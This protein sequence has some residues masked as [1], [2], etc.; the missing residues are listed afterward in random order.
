M[1][2]RHQQG[3][4]TRSARPHPRRSRRRHNAQWLAA[5]VAVLTTVVGGWLLAWF[6]WFAGPPTDATAP[7]SSGSGAQL[8]GPP[9]LVNVYHEGVHRSPVDGAFAFPNIL[10]LSKA[11]LHFMDTHG[12]TAWAVP[13][14]GYDLPSTI[15]KLTVTARRRVRILGMRAVIL[16]TSTRPTG[17][18]LQPAEQG[19]VANTAVDIGLSNASPEAM[20]VGKNGLPTREPYFKRYSYVL[21]SG[22]QATFE[23]TAYPGR[24]LYQP[25]GRGQAYRWLLDI[26]LLDQNR[27]KD[28]LIKDSGGKPFATTDATAS[29]AAFKAVYTQCLYPEI[30]VAACQNVPRM[31]WTRQ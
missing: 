7:S 20:M 14:G 4:G 31:H 30:P 1:T 29:A 21:A 24:Q 13:H 19:A 9:M 25:A 11:D 3:G 15:V 27:T 5:V 6:T 22:E 2:T 12:V 10:R 18:L 17:T 8:S 26:T 16:S 23:I 28:M